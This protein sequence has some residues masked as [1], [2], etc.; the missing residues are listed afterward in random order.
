MVGVFVLLASCGQRDTSTEGDGSIV[1]YSSQDDYVLAEAVS[2]FEAETGISVRVVGD[3]EATKTVGLV[4]RL[5]LEHELNEGPGAIGGSSGGADVW[6]SNEPFGSVRLSEAGVLTPYTSQLAQDAFEGGW[7]GTLVGERK[8]WY[9]HALRARVL[10]WSTD[11][12]PEPPSTLAGL[13]SG[14]WAG[15][16]GIARPEFG[17]TRGHMA[18][19][20][21]AWGPER[22]EAWL[23]ELEAN[24]VRVYDSNSSVV[25]AVWM[26]EIDAGLTDT[27][28]VLVGQARGWG[29]AMAQPSDV[30]LVVP[31]TVGLVA[32]GA[33][34]AGGKRFIDWLLS[35]AGE[36]VLWLSESQNTPVS[37]AATEEGERATG[38]GIS[39]PGGGSGW[40]E[41]IAERE[42]E[43]MAICDRVLGGG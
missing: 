40:Y 16:V 14:D 38:T 25:R 15:R 37:P 30:P 13:A 1:L 11:R 9:A 3:S 12:V 32:G 36:R 4:N 5:L 27:D 29:V 8:D 18:S 39:V 34:P 21:Q 6:W 26:G 22:F 23:R 28:D 42:T 35:G 41:A 7:P 20:A 31:S 10:V 33:D 2:A 19:I 24:G 43:A 17:T